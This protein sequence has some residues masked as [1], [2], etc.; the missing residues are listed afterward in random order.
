MK[1]IKVQFTVR[2]NKSGSDCVDE[3]EVEVPE[4]ACEKEVEERV[5][6]VYEEWMQN[7][8]DGFWKILE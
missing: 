5:Q 4:N 1:L 2:T 8:I 6:I 3:L 7:N